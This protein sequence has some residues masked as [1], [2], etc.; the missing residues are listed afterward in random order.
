[1]LD[2]D[3]RCIAQYGPGPHKLCPRFVDVHC[4][5]LGLLGLDGLK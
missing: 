1:M 4:T 3:P 2:L 5:D